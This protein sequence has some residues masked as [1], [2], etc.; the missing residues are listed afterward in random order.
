MLRRFS[1]RPIKVARRRLRFRPDH[2]AHLLRRHKRILRLIIS[3]LLLVQAET[4]QARIVRLRPVRRVFVLRARPRF[5]SLIR[6]G[7]LD[8]HRT[9]RILRQ[10]PEKPW[11]RLLQRIGDRQS[12]Q[13]AHAPTTLGRIIQLL[14]QSSTL[15]REG[16]E[17]G[18]GRWDGAIGHVDTRRR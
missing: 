14:R 4:A 18:Q 17:R 8:R 16:I 3:F 1:P 15:Q 5:L 12:R 2:I 9:R 10:R 6:V 13:P 11:P 7:P